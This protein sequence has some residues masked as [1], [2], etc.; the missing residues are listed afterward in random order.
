MS[1]GLSNPRRSVKICIAM[2]IIGIGGI[3]W[4]VFEMN[5]R[6]GA[7]T[8]GTA[9]AIGGGLLL[10]ILGFLFLFNFIWAVRLTSAMQRGENVIG[11]WTV[12]QQTLEEFRT[13]EAERK[14]TGRLNDWKVPRK[15]PANGIEVIFSPSAVM[16]GD[17]FFGLS[18]SGM[19]RFNWVQTVPGNPLSI[20]FGMVMTTGRATS[21]G[22]TLTTQRSE[23][24]IPV[25]RG[26]SAEASKVLEH[27]TSVTAGQTIARPG[28]WA[29]RVKIGLWA[30]G[31]GAVSAA[32]GFGLNAL[33]VDLAEAPLVMAVVGVMA[34]LGGLILAGLATMLGRHERADRTR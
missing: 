32:T 2:L 1:A 7:E 16:I 4:G 33:K 29:L 18:K 19:A 3:L 5:R 28:F 11:R 9:I 30:A 21:S 25:A 27:Y 20:G 14:K 23:L 10:T 31:I 26:A 12:P 13:D 6:G 34:G 24:R 8:G 17:N 15:I 22:A